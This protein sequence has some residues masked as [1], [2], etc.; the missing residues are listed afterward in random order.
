MVPQGINE[1]VFLFN[2]TTENIL[3]K[4]I[5]TRQL[6]VM[7]ETHLGLTTTLSS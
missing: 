6:L 5:P 7:I 4:Y 1:M 2:D 3:S